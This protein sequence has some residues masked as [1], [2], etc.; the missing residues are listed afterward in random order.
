MRVC[1]SAGHVHP[2][3]WFC[4]IYISSQ[5]VCTSVNVTA[6]VPD[7][8]FRVA[9]ELSLSCTFFDVEERRTKTSLVR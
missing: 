7:D 2:E 3:R 9:G 8:L 1:G 4:K 5:L 6:L